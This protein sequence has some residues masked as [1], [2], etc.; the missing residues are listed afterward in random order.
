MLLSLILLN[1]V[2][3]LFVVCISSYYRL[4]PKNNTKKKTYDKIDNIYKVKF[5]KN[6]RNQNDEDLHLTARKGESP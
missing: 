6:E 5:Y 1:S 4:P 3:C 2:V